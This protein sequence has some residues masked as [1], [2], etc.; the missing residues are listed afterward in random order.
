MELLF[1]CSPCLPAKHGP[2]RAAIN[3]DLDRRLLSQRGSRGRVTGAR[4]KAWCL[5]IHA[6]ASLSLSHGRVMGESCGSHGVNGIIRRALPAKH[7]AG[8]AV[9]GVD[10]VGQGLALVPLH[11]CSLHSST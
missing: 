7:G 9:E 2:R 3:R 11:S 5:L 1:L 8:L 6:D 10:N 4:A